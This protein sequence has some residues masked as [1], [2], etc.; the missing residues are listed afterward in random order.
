MP[1]SPLSQP[2]LLGG[3][4]IY[5]MHLMPKLAACQKNQLGQ[6]LAK[7]VL[8]LTQLMRLDCVHCI[9]CDCCKALEIFQKRV[10]TNL[11]MARDVCLFFIK[12]HGPHFGHYLATKSI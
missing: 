12:S 10:G 9:L 3:A 2:H 5:Q 6:H 4:S 11:L 7:S 1:W 8:N